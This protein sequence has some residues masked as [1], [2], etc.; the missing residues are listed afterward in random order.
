[1]SKKSDA[2]NLNCSDE[3]HQRVEII[4]GCPV[5]ILED[6]EKGYTIVCGNQILTREWYKEKSECIERINKTDW[7]LIGVVLYILGEDVAMRTFA[8]MK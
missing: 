2:N 3:R 8:K 1:M 4:P 5:A 6:S 7:E